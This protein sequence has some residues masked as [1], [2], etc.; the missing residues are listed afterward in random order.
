MQ[1]I[2]RTLILS[3]RTGLRVAIVGCVVT[4]CSFAFAQSKD[5]DT[6]LKDAGNKISNIVYTTIGIVALLVIGFFIVRWCFCRFSR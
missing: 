3:L 5:I 2:V 4:I 1:N 6:L